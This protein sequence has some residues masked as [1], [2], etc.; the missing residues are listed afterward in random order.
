MRLQNA[1]EV[2]GMPVLISRGCWSVLIYPPD[3]LRVADWHFKNIIW[4]MPWVL[5]HGW[6]S[7]SSLWLLREGPGHP[8]CSPAFPDRCLGLGGGMACKWTQEMG[9]TLPTP[10]EFALLMTSMLSCLFCC[11]GAGSEPFPSLPFLYHVSCGQ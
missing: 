5:L 11:C 10:G 3:L 2:H 1:G 6:A 9:K 7:G 4:G 8:R